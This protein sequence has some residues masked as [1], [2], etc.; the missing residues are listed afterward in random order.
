ME[1]HSQ[2][3]SK[4]LYET[5][6]LRTILEFIVILTPK[7]TTCIPGIDQSLAFSIFTLFVMPQI[8]FKLNYC[9]YQ[10]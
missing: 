4:S 7:P 1:S 8:W 10:R 6:L 3:T 5:T 9:M 2:T